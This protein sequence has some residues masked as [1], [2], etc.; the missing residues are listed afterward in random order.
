VSVLRAIVV[1]IALVPMAIGGRL[2]MEGLRAPGWY[3]LGIGVVLFVATLFER[4]RYRDT[5]TR[6]PRNWQPTDERFVDPETGRTLRVFYDPA[7]GER[8]YVSDSPAVEPGRGPS[9]PASSD[10]GRL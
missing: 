2:I 3:L 6:A 5:L 1:L 8:H 9:P 7:S 4:W 10:A